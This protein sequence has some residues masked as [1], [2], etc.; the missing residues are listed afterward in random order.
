MKPTHLIV[1]LGNPEGKYFQTYH[2]LGFLAVDEIAK[3]HNA[4]F[5]KKGNQMTV[6]IGNAILL[7]PLTYMNLSGQAVVAV[8]RKFKIAPENIIVIVDDLYIEKGSIRLSLVEVVADIMG[9]GQLTNFLVQTS[10]HAF[11]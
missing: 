7:K 1:G 10:T 3:R 6:Q 11:V 9:F 4:E 8:S 2:N 5:K